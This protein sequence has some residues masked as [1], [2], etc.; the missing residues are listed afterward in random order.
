MVYL[1]PTSILL[2]RGN[3]GTVVLSYDRNL[4]PSFRLTWDGESGIGS[5]L[6]SMA[7]FKVLSGS[8][9][10]RDNWLLSASVVESESLRSLELKKVRKLVCKKDLFIKLETIYFF[11][12][13]QDELY[14]KYREKKK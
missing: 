14:S 3:T 5:A 1:L 2:L 11:M 13:I 10:D 8:N 7:V 12:C 6:M 9:L 4:D